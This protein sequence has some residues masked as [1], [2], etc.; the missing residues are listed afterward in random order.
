LASIDNRLRTF[1]DKFESSVRS[2]AGFL[3]QEMNL[4]IKMKATGEKCYCLHVSKRSPA[5]S[6][7]GLYLYFM[8]GILRAFGEW[9]DSR[10][11][12]HVSVESLE[13]D[14]LQ[15]TVCLCVRQIQ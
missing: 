5:I 11:D 10:R 7:D 2:L 3:A 14:H 1:D 6:G 9:L 15:D 13:N 4:P 8:A 12:Y